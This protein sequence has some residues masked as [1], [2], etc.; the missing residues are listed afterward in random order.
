MWEL[1][2]FCSN[3]LAVINYP[4]YNPND[5]NMRHSLAQNETFKSDYYILLVFANIA[6][7]LIGY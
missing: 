2:D 1:Q 7:S 5:D 4:I 6:V 3:G